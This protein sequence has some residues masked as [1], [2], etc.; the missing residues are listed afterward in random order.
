MGNTASDDGWRYR[1]RGLKQLTSR[2][3]YAEYAEASRV[4]VVRWPELLVKPGYA[5][6][7]AGWFWHARGCNSFADDADVRGLTKRINGDETTLRE[8]AALTAKALKALI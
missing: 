7:S 8:R 3:N 5:A 1:G 2:S 4:D 6:D